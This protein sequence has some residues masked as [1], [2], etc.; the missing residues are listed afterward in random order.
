MFY[1]ASTI[2]YN[3]TLLHDTIEFAAV[4]SHKQDLPETKAE[5]K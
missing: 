1:F 5:G 4:T 3:S 2:W